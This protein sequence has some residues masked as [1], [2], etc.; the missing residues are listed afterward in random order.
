M[1]KKTHLKLS[2]MLHALSMVAGVVGTFIFFS[3]WLGYPNAMM[4]GSPTGFL[5]IA[6]WLMLAARYAMKTE[7]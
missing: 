3:K 7:K 2:E 4:V 6:I 1:H 5:L